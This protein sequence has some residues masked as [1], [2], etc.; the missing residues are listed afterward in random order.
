ML[1]F[2]LTFFKT[3]ILF[4]IP[5]ESV[6]SAGHF[7]YNKSQSM[8]RN[9]FIDP[10][11]Y[12]PKN[13]VLRQ[14]KEKSLFYLSC[15]LIK[16]T[17][18]SRSL[19][20]RMKLVMIRSDCTSWH[21]T[22]GGNRPCMPSSCLSSMLNAIPLNKLGLRNNSTPLICERGL[23]KRSLSSMALFLTVLACCT[24]ILLTMGVRRRSWPANKPLSL[25]LSWSMLLLSFFF[26]FFFSFSIFV[27]I[28]VNRVEI[29]FFAF[30]FFFFFFRD[31]K[32]EFFFVDECAAEFCVRLL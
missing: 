8:A 10:C 6:E 12:I 22:A 25:F 32:C 19:C 14:K 21:K 9:R 28:R 2:S 1:F 4:F 23:D 3:S 16:S 17:Q 26:Y 29:W 27:C 24:P 13:E 11:T 31:K 5:L 15:R 7:C 30:F 18:R 20:S